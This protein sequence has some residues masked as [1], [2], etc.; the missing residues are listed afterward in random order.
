MELPLKTRKYLRAI[1][2]MIGAKIAIA[3]IGPGRSQTIIL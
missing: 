2:K 3:S 1:A